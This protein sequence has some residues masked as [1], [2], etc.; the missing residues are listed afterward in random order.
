VAVAKGSAY[1]RY[2]AIN[3]TAD[4]TICNIEMLR[5][6]DFPAY[7]TFIVDE[8]HRIKNRSA[9][10]SV[11]AFVIAQRTPRLIELTGTPITKTPDDYYMQLRLIDFTT[12]SSYWRF[13]DM[14]CE[15]E[16][17]PWGDKIIGA[18]SSLAPMLSKYV[19]QRSYEDVCLELPILIST[20]VPVRVSANIRAIYKDVQA[21][22]RL[23]DLDIP[24]AAVLVQTLRQLLIGT[25][26]LHVLKELVSDLNEPIVIYCWYRSAVEYIAKALKCPAITG[27]VRPDD[28]LKIAKQQHKVICAT[29]ASM[30]E[31]VD[32]SYARVVIYFECHYTPGTMT[33]TLMRVQRWS[34]NTAPV[35]AY[36]L[37][38]E[39]TVD[40]VVY[41]AH[42]SRETTI[43]DIARAA[44]QV[45]LDTG[46]KPW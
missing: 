43:L 33:Q 9:Q 35:R 32:L 16:P 42:T 6:Y 29:M 15:V 30:Q 5:N 40:E 14:F 11:A 1:K 7:S 25:D 44:L 21:T 45:S 28:R 22:Y 31:G 36:Y 41:A 3:K 27:A 13:V 34:P 20:V 24:N 26:K 8:S 18:K 10:Q 37:L 38:C 2:K 39:H 17:T 4:W 19:L 23:L 46:R 12:F